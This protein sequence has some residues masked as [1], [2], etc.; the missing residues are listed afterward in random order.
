MTDTINILD[1][2]R[3]LV[4][5]RC[6]LDAELDDAARRDRAITSAVAWFSHHKPRRGDDP[7]HILTTETCTI[8][9]LFHAVLAD[10]AA[11]II[12]D[13]VA[14]RLSNDDDPALPMAGEVKTTP[15]SSAF[16][17][18]AKTLR[19]SSYDGIG[20]QPGQVRAA[21]SRANV[22]REPRGGHVDPAKR[23]GGS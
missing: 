7:V 16:A 19:Q 21:S 8:S 11:A 1:T 17:A 3:Q 12:L 13:G 20:A 14:A 18:R 4:D 22:N 15:R 23:G 5:D 10:R 9:P 2:I 6:Q